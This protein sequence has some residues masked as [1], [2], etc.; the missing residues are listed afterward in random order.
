MV[1]VN[2]TDSGKIIRDHD[3]VCGFLG[4][5]NIRYER[6]DI[7]KISSS[8]RTQEAILATFNE[9]IENISNKG[10]YT[11]ADVINIDPKTPNLESMLEKFKREHRHSEDEVR[12]IIDGSGIFFIHTE[13]NEV[14]S[15][16][17]EPGD[18][19]SVPAG[20]KHWFD[21]CQDRHI[22]AIRLFQDRSGWVPLYTG[23]G[24]DGKYE[25]VCF[26]LSYIGNHGDSP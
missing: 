20:T 14:F 4:K 9:E 12:F 5:R 16:E 8:E 10:G 2:I 26:G 18:L 1:N 11:T 21:L 13:Q 3:E 6:W 25:P 19:L 7:S 24:I 15:V 17:V 22:I 23:S